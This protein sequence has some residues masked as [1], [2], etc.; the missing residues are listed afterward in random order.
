MKTHKTPP[1][2]QPW[3][4]A[5]LGIL[6]ILASTGLQAQEVQEARTLIGQ[7]SPINSDDIGV[8]IA[9]AFAV[10]SLDGSTAPLFHLRGGATLKDQWSVGGYFSVLLDEIYPQSETELGIYMEYWSAGGFIEYTLLSK[11]LLHL[12]F[13][14]YI[15][16]GEVELDNELRDEELGEIYFF[17]IEPSALLELNLHRYVRF[18]LGAGYRFAGQMN[19]RNMDQSD[20]RGLT[21]YAGLRI[22]WFR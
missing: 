2:R 17:Q 9:P 14:L 4:A 11:K 10:T 21:G 3:S 19:Y 18:N 13:P 16:Y 1:P 15:G 20:I 6:I 22:G 12:T 5:L 7:G 8:F